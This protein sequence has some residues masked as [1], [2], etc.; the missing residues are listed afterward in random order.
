MGRYKG[1]SLDG[2]FLFFVGLVVAGYGSFQI[3]GIWPTMLWLGFVLMWL[4]W[5]VL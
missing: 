4:G 5:L 3:F 2:I 1:D